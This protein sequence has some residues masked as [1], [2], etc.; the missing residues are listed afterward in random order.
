MF[1]DNQIV[2]L[3]VSKAVGCRLYSIPLMDVELLV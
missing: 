2:L 1:V 3:T